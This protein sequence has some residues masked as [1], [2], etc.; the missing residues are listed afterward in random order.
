M[1][2]SRFAVMCITKA[3][4]HSAQEKRVECMLEARRIVT[5]YVWA[6]VLRFD[7]KQDQ[8]FLANNSIP[9]KRFSFFGC[10]VCVS[11]EGKRRPP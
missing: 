10:C 3:K 1:L 9:R 6:T 11:G 7:T 2:A 8:T 4:V 5:Y